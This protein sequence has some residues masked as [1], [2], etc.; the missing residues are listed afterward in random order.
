MLFANDLKA[1]KILKWSPFA[2]IL[3]H[4]FMTHLAKK[5]FRDLDLTV[6]LK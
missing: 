2:D 3:L 5:C 6:A 1:A 4:S